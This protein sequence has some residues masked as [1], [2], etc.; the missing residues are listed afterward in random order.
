M[1]EMYITYALQ[2]KPSQLAN[3]AFTGLFASRVGCLT[4]TVYIGFSKHEM[5][6]LPTIRTQ[7]LSICDL[8]PVKG[9]VL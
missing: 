4:N 7:W 8:I 1:W 6:I 5:E 9:Q 2:I 3:I